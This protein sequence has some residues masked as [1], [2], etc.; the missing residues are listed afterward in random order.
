ML[1]FSNP[2]LFAEFDNW[3]SGS[4]TVKCKFE[5][6]D[7]GKKGFRVVKT[8][9]NPKTGK[10]N[11]PKLKTYGGKAAIVDGSDGKTYI[12]QKTSYMIRVSSHDF[13]DSYLPGKNAASLTPDDDLYATFLELIESAV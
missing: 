3:P 13:L 7:G 1:P 4:H 5:V 12:I 9:T 2:R 6:E 10:W 11:K 8:T